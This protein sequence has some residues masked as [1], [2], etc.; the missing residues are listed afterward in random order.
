[1][2]I[3]GAGN[4]CLQLCEGVKQHCPIASLKPRWAYRLKIYMLPSN[5]ACGPLGDGLFANGA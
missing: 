3:M 2:N 4:R 5:K 1:M